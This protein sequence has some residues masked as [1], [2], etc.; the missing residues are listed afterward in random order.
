[1]GIL[2]RRRGEDDGPAGGTSSSG[3][4]TGGEVH[5]LGGLAEA[6]R[7]ERAGMQKVG[8]PDTP[9]HDL[10]PT[11]ARA[12]ALAGPVSRGAVDPTTL[13]TY[14]DVEAYTDDRIDESVV[15]F[16]PSFVSVAF[17]GG[18]G[19]YRLASIHGA[20]GGG[21]WKA[22]RT[23]TSLLGSYDDV[24]VVDELGDA[25][26]RTGAFT[27]VRSGDVILFA[28]VDREDLGPDEATAMREVLLRGALTS[29]SPSAAGGG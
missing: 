22:A 5:G 17:R 23:W 20:E 9:D 29:L 26:F 1:M 14:D 2:D 27:L 25:A 7:K 3:D 4:G 10:T 13:L 6:F 8:K 16:A 18:A 24:A 21:R 12:A 15:G 19:T 11:E 28:E